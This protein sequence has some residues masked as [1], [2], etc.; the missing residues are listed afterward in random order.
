MSRPCYPAGAIDRV[1][2]WLSIDFIETCRSAR[3]RQLIYPDVQPLALS[4]IL[5]AGAVDLLTH[6]QVRMC[7][8]VCLC[9]CGSGSF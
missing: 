1:A 5:V 4:S 3:L 6:V 7:V 9:V 2:G 8:W